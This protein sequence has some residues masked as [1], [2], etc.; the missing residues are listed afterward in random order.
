MSAGLIAVLFV[1]AAL[2]AVGVFTAA[3]RRDVTALPVAKS[4]LEFWQHLLERDI[5]GD[6]QRRIVRDIIL[7]VELL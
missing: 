1:A 3:W 6:E 5:T 4:V 7:I 2:V